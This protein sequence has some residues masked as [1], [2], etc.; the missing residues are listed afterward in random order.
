MKADMTADVDAM[1]QLM[2]S[3]T[4][5]IVGS[6]PQVGA[7]RAEQGGSGAWQERSGFFPAVVAREVFSH[8]SFSFFLPSRARPSFPAFARAAGSLVPARRDGPDRGHCR[9]RPQER[10][11]PDAGTLRFR[12]FVC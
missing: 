8:P 1:A 7:R 5:C 2:D 11:F 4:I 10:Y 6:A 3:N 9:P 12:H